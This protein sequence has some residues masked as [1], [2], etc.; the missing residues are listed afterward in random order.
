MER[1][2][3]KPTIEG[4]G[5][6]WHPGSRG[7]LNNLPY[8]L[9][10]GSMKFYRVRMDYTVYPHM[11]PG[12]GIRFIHSGKYQWVVEGQEIELFPD[13]ISVTNPW[14]LYGSPYGK[15]EIGEYSWMVIKPM[16]YTLN[17]PLNLGLW[18]QLPQELQQNLG[19]Q[20]T[21]EKTIVL[22]KAKKLR[23]YFLE[24]KVELKGQK[25]GYEIVVGNLIDNFFIDLFR[26]LSLK[27]QQIEKND[28]FI[29]DLK[30]L[31]SSDLIRKWLIEDLAS[32]FGMGKTKFTEEVRNLTGYP[33]ASFIIN[34]RIDK[35]LEM[36]KE[37]KL[38]LSDIAYSC[39][40]SSLQHFTSTFSNRIGVSP[41][42]FRKS[43]KV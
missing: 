4:Q 29:D 6:W 37:E 16:S 19:Q 26:Q 31:I 15:T 42:R 12:I 23:K 39:G 33:P 5:V 3:I 9:Q 10:F 22:R 28:N 17:A 20:L 14:Q 41:G 11:H 21:E 38:N 25:T 8:I 40:F 2:N 35:S 34:L 32:K 13:D 43:K 36:L 24:L 18:T 30:E 27:Q 7:P 1:H